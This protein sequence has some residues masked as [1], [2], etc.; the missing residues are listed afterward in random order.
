MNNGNFSDRLLAMERANPDFREKYERGVKAMLE[1]RL[2][3]VQKFVTGFMAVV[4]LAMFAFF[5]YAVLVITAGLPVL[6][7][8]SFGV[9]ALFSLAFLIFLVKIVLSGKMNLRTQ[10]N[11]MT[12]LVWVFLV[13]MQTIFMTIGGKHPE[14]VSS[15]FMVLYGLSFLVLGVAFLVTH[16]I[17][18][19]ELNVK[20]KLLGIELRLAE[21]CEKSEKAQE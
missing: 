4:C 10:P 18:Q 17:E 8:A 14:S 16:R 1:K 12:G 3:P 5:T 21:L 11:T 19:S 15:V 20:E 9:G 6:I 7:R 13:I 2:T